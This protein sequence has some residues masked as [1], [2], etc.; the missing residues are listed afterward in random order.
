MGGRSQARMQALAIDPATQFC[1]DP[2]DCIRDLPYFKS[3]SFLSPLAASEAGLVLVVYLGV[4]A[5]RGHLV[6]A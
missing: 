3:V 2:A 6:P 5:V 4:P 1:S